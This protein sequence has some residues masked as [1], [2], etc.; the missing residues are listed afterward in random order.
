MAIEFFLTFLI[1]LVS[2]IH[3]LVY[4]VILFARSILF[5]LISLILSV[6]YATIVFVYVFIVAAV[7][8]VIVIA[9]LSYRTKPT[10]ES[11]KEYLENLFTIAKLEGPSVNSKKVQTVQQNQ[12]SQQINSYIT[13]IYEITNTISSKAMETAEQTL[14]PVYHMDMGP[15][16]LAIVKEENGR[17]KF[18]GAFG[19]W[20][21]SPI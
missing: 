6:A 4:G 13:K 15:F 2:E 12:K 9:V 1:F 10:K 19:T 7:P 5:E 11:F 3:H 16:R 18:I 20:F 21:P 17:Q 14:L 8:A